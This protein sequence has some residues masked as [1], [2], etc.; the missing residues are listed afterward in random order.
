MVLSH[1]TDESNLHPYWYAHVVKIFHVN[2]HH[3][4]DRSRSDKVQHKDVLL[5]R[6]FGRNLG[7]RSGF[8]A[9]RLPRLE[10]LSEDDPDAFIFL[11]PDVVICGVHLIPIARQEE[12]G[13]ED[14]QS[15]DV[16]MYVPTLTIYD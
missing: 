5:V 15:F 13:D 9:R 6:W 1:E 14:W 11:D 7:H 16:N 8:G 2:I 10:F 3:Y 12:D 4:G